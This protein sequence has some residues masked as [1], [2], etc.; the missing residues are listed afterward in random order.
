MFHAFVK[1]AMGG[2]E[3]EGEMG[4]PEGAEERGTW[5]FQ[6]SLGNSLQGCKGA[7]APT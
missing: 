7:V 4:N 5:L 1:E 6:G 3:G 2:A